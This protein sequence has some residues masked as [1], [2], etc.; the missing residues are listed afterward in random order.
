MESNYGIEACFGSSSG[1][2][3]AYSEE[4]GEVFLGVRRIV[5]RMKIRHATSSVFPFETEDDIHQLFQD[6]DFLLVLDVVGRLYLLSLP[7]ETVV[8]RMHAKGAKAAQLRSGKVYVEH[9]GSL[10]EWV[11][12]DNGFFPFRKLKHVPGHSEHISRVF[13]TAGTFFTAGEFGSLRTC[14]FDLGKSLSVH[15]TKD[16]VLAARM[17]GTELVFVTSNG[18]VVRLSQNGPE[19]KQELRK[20]TSVRASGASISKHC[21]MVVIVDLKNQASIYSAYSTS[22]EPVHSIS[23]P[24][25]ITAA[26][27]VED[28]SWIVLSGTGLLIWEWRSGSLITSEQSATNHTAAVDTSNS[29]ITATAQG[30]VFIWD[31]ASS[32][33]TASAR[34]HASKIIALLPSV[35]G[36]ISVSVG[37]SIKS[38][39]DSGEVLKVIDRASYTSVAHGDSEI[40]AVAG[41]GLLE[42]YDVKRGT[43]MLHTEVD[44]PLAVFLHGVTALAVTSSGITALS[45]GGASITPGPEP[46]VLADISEVKEGTRISCLGES[47]K[48]YVYSEDAEEVCEYQALPPYRNRIGKVQPLSMKQLSDSSTVITY[49][50]TRSDR[51][52]DTRNTLRASMYHGGHEMD[53]WSV[54][55]RASPQDSGKVFETATGRG[56]GIGICVSFGALVYTNSRTSFKPAVFLTRETPQQ[57]RQKIEEGDALGGLVGAVLLKNTDLARYALNTGSPELLGKYFP[58]SFAEDLLQILL[59]LISEGAVGQSLD[60]MQ[61]LLPRISVPPM[62]QKQLLLLL[63]GP[64]R[65][66]VE[67]TGIIDGL[68]EFTH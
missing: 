22:S 66:S 52:T 6:G 62:L 60:I 46:F 50:I 30:D 17:H 19:W 21:D 14:D 34:G 13:I 48:V 5:K 18:D 7:S 61:G 54:Q 35:R 4:T 12:D 16:P 67:T 29:L 28:D 31:K 44:L 24:E 42:M 9:E 11:P 41:P 3:V 63:S 38:H 27:F 26:E 20:H 53:T 23:V 1:C 57:L 59:V 56:L 64:F 10:Q 45:P 43:A 65:V 36:F 37:G 68:L 40:V 51:N 15:A 8:G 2:A 39:S 33:A 25:G 32:L 49:V 47:G 58:T 55:E